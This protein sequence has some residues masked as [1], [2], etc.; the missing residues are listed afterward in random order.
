M[1]VL[2]AIISATGY[3]NGRFR[4]AA[5]PVIIVAAS[6]SIVTLRE[7]RAQRARLG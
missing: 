7:R 5:E 4:I 6:M 3:G 2:V 1:I